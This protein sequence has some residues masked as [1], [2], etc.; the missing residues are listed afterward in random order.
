[1][2]WLRFGLFRETKNKKFSFVSVFRTY[3]EKNETNRTVLKQTKTTLNFLKNTKLCSLSN[4]FGWSSVCF[5]SIETSKLSVSVQKRNNRKKL[6]RKK[7]K[8]NVTNQNNLKCSEKNTKICSLSN[9]FSCSSVC[10]V[11]IKTLKLS[12]SALLL[13]FSTQPSLSTHPSKWCASHFPNL[14][15]LPSP[16]RPLN[17]KCMVHTFFGDRMGAL[18]EERKACAY[19]LSSR[20]LRDKERQ[21]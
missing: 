2:F 21:F 18:N 1:M 19:R 3:N 4:C 10:F 13:P 15:Y 20:E 11:S 14:Q 17:I 12:V 6:F 8:Q 16:N 5:G 7:P 9:C